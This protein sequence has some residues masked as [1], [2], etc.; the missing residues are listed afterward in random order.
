MVSTTLNQLAGMVSTGAAAFS[1]VSAS[2]IRIRRNVKTPLDLRSRF[3]IQYQGSPYRTAA[4]ASSGRRRTADD[5]QQ[6]RHGVLA[7]RRRRR[8]RKGAAV[9]RMFLWDAH[10]GGEL[11]K[12]LHPRAGLDRDHVVAVG[13]LPVHDPDLRLVGIQAEELP[14]SSSIGL[15]LRRDRLPGERHEEPFALR[16]LVHLDAEPDRPGFLDAP[17]GPDHLHELRV[18]ELPSSARPAVREPVHALN[19]DREQDVRPVA[20]LDQLHQADRGN[21]RHQGS[22]EAG[23]GERHVGDRGAVGVLTL[24]AQADATVGDPGDNVLELKMLPAAENEVCSW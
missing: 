18:R 5:A 19:R 9:A 23:P 8:R 16:L 12:D 14:N 24:G 2:V 3:S 13:A 1:P 17:E 6:G 11:E 21:R 10:R 15:H 7:G 20:G 22:D 4:K